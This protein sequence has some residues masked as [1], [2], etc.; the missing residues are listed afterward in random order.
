[1]SAPIFSMACRMYAHNARRNPVRAER[2]LA[3]CE[4]YEGKEA[5]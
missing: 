4:R 5:A 1:M 2:W 3:V